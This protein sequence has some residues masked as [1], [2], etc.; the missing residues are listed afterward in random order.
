MKPHKL[1]SA[2]ALLTA[3][4][5]Q[6]G[7]SEDV[8]S[9]DVRTSGFYAEFEALALGDGTTEVSARLKI[10]GKNSNTFADL[11][12]EDTLIAFTDDDEVTMRRSGSGNRSPYEAEFDTEKGGTEFT[13]NF[14]RGS[15]DDSAP[16]SMATLPKPFALSLTDLEEGDE[17]VRGNDVSLEW[18]DNASGTLNWEIEGDCI[19]S[20]DGT[21]ADDGDL[22]I[23]SSDVRVQSLD[24]GESCEVTVTL[25]RV[26]EGSVDGGYDGGKFNAVQRRS[27]RFTSTPADD[28][29]GVGGAGGSDS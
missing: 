22:V 28:E 21:A 16:D 25:E 7:C 4:A 15:F 11:T 27:I 29:T 14:D 10:G 1:L 18:D 6:L 8:D 5:P 26:N 9:E 3:S 23:D 12:G 19:W 13:V 17:I 20:E 24:E 2:L